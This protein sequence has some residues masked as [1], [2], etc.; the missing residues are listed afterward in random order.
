[1]IR[2][3][4]NILIGLLTAY[5]LIGFVVLGSYPLLAYYYG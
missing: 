1:M 4:K 5:I 2:L 3:I